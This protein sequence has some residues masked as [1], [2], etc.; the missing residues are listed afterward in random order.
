[1]KAI[2]PQ[3]YQWSH[4]VPERRRDANGIFVQGPPGTPGALIDPV[5]FHRGDEAEVWEQGGAGA[6]VLTRA[7]RERLAELLGVPLDLLE[8]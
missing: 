2:A 1:M 5:P 7:E 8:D 6:V 4:Y 3:V